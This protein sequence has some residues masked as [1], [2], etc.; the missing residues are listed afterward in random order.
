[1]QV[2]V[3]ADD[4]DVACPPDRVWDVLADTSSHATW[5]PDFRLRTRSVEP[6]SRVLIIASLV[7]GPPLLLPAV[8]LRSQPGHVLSWG[9]NV[10]G[11]LR[12]EH[13]FELEAVDGGTRVAHWERFAGPGAVAV[14]PL[15]D[16]LRAAYSDMS[17][18]LRDRVEALAG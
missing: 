11:L 5:S 8:V 9:G 16:R 15:A 7:P 18:R 12:L 10:A 2:V 17:R 4:V 1:V 3:R 13:A 14:R 6:G